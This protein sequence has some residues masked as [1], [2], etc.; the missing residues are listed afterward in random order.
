MV[1][2]PTLGNVSL[3]DDPCATWSRGGNGLP[4]GD[5]EA[6]GCDAE[7]A[8]VVE[9]SP[10]S[11]F[12][13]VEAHLLL[14]F[15]I[16]AFVVPEAR[17]LRDAPTQFGGV[18]ELGEVDVLRQRRKQVFGRLFFLFRP[19]DQQPFV[20]ASRA[21]RVTMRSRRGCRRRPWAARSAF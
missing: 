17:S 18:D 9:A 14:V 7:C 5:Q 21:R 1:R 16:I 11:P 4:L 15:L 6:V 2:A 12:V 13:V 8:V 3:R 20:G 19:L 10:A